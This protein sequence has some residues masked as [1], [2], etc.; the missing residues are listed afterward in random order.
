MNKLF[1]VFSSIKLPVSQKHNMTGE[2]FYKIGYKHE[3]QPS[4]QLECK[5][6]ELKYRL[7]FKIHVLVFYLYQS[8]HSCARHCFVVILFATELKLKNVV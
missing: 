6:I 4:L 2:I 3:T 5:R 1:S 7:S 8:V